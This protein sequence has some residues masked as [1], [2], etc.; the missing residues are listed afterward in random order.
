MKLRIRQGCLAFVILLVVAIFWLEPAAAEILFKADFET[1][2]FSQFSGKSKNVKPGHIEVV[3]DIVHSGK[4]AGRFTIHEDNVF[5]ARQLRV[6]ANGPKVTVKE[7][8]D[9][10]VSFYMYMKDPPKDRDNFFYWEGSPPPGYNNVMTWW[11]GPKEDGAG[12]IHQIRHRQPGTKG[13]SLGA[14]FHDRPMASTGH[15]HSLVGRSGPGKC[16]GSGGTAWSS[17]IRRSRRRGRKAST[18]PSRE[19]IATRIPNRLTPFISMTSS[20]PRRLRRSRF[21]NRTRRS[22][23]DWLRRHEARHRFYVDA[24]S[25]QCASSWR[26]SSDRRTEPPPTSDSRC[27]GVSL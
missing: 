22:R 21:R 10:F 18:F 4:Y 5:N 9:T 19:F 20:A 2:D 1:G 3:T 12:T 7:G 11:V 14:G 6:Q 13:R 16:R 25:A 24:C 26:R 27:R 17:W 15:A 23:N 8:S